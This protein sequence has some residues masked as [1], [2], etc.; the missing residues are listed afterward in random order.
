MISSVLRMSRC[1]S[2]AEQ[3][4]LTLEEPQQSSQLLEVGNSFTGPKD[5]TADQAS[6]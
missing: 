4:L 2:G 6:N 1:E 5:N 3:P